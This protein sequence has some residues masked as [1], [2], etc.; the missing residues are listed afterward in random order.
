MSFQASGQKLNIVINFHK[1]DQSSAR[2]LLELLV[3][4]DEGIE[5][6]YYL[7]YGDETATIR[8]EETLL[9]FIETKNA[10]FSNKFPDIV[11]PDE[12]IKNDVNQ[13]R[14]NGNHTFKS[15]VQ[16]ARILCWNLAVYKY[17]NKLDHFLIIE[18]DCVIMRED[19]AKPIFE[20]WSN[21][22]NPIVGH[23]KRGK[24]SGQLIPTHWAGCSVY[25]GLALRQLP[26]EKYFYE[27]YENPWWPLRSE[28]GTTT[29]NNAF[30]GPAI[31]GYDIS[32]DYFLFALYFRELT[33]SN[34]PLEWPLNDLSSIDDIIL[35]DFKSKLRVEEIFEQ[36]YGRL[37]VL[38]GIK[39]DLVHHAVLRT[40][41]SHNTRE[42]LTFPIGGGF[43]FADQ[44]DTTTRVDSNLKAPM[45]VPAGEVFAV[46]QKK[47][48]VL[49]RS[50]SRLVSIKDLRSRFSG[51]RCFIIGNGPSL[52]NTDLT[53][54][55][56][57]FTIGLNRIYLNYPAMGFQPTFYCSVNPSV[58]EQFS[59]EIDS[60]NS[61]KFLR[62]DSAKHLANQWNTFFMKSIRGIGFNENLENQ[63]WFE[64]WT[65]TFCAMQVAYHLGFNDVVL[66]GVD[67][68]FE[69]S[70]KPN[71]TVR[72]TADD[73]NHFDPTYFG[74][75]VVW[76]YPDLE[77]SEQSYKIAKEIF[78]SDGRR[79]L[80]AT[81]GGH[82]KIFEKAD[83]D[84]L[85]AFAA[86]LHAPDVTSPGAGEPRPLVSVIM[87]AQDAADTIAESIRSVQAQDY[88][89]WELLIIN[90]LSQ[91]S[92][93]EIVARFQEKDSRIRIL[94]SAGIGTSA[95]RNTGLR[96]AA[97]AFIT[98]LDSDDIY[99]PGSIRKRV[100]ALQK[101]PTWPIVSCDAHLIDDGFRKLGIRVRQNKSKFTFADS[102]RNL[103][104]NSLMGRAAVLRRFSFDSEHDGVED[105]VYLSR[106]LRAG[107]SVFEV[108][109][110]AVAYRI[111]ANSV[112]TADFRAHEE[113]CRRVINLVYGFDSKCPN[114]VPEYVNGLTSPDK[115][116][117]VAKRQIGLLT[118][119]ILGRKL[120]D[121]ARLIGEIDA[122][123]VHKMG[124][125]DIISAMQMATIRFFSCKSDKWKDRL[126]EESDR[127]LYICEKGDVTRVLPRYVTILFKC[128]QVSEKQ[129]TTLRARVKAANCEQTYA[130]ID[131]ATLAG[132]YDRE[133][134]AHFDE[135]RLAYEL[136]S[137]RPAKSVMIDV[138]AHH[139]SAL[140]PFADRGW[141]VY[142]FEPDSANREKLLKRVK[143]NSLVS[144]D[145]RAVCD[146]I[147]ESVPLY[148]SKE[149]TGISTLAP[150][151]DSHKKSSRVGTTTLAAVSEEHGLTDVDFLKIDTEGYDLMVL[152]GLP[153]ECWR[154]TVIVC[155]FEDRKTVPLGYDYHQ[156]AGFLVDKGYAVLVS[157][158][159]PVIR[160]GI[161]HDW[162]RLIPYPCRL[163]D[164][165]SWGNLIAFP[166]PP[167]LD[168]VA[169][170]AQRIVTSEAGKAP[171]T[172]RSTAER[173]TSPE[174]SEPVRDK[175]GAL[176]LTDRGAKTGEAARMREPQETL[177]QRFASYLILHHP[178]LARIARF[179]LWSLRK[180]KERM[181]GLGGVALLSIGGLFAGA[182][183]S[184][185]YR[186]L[187][188]GAGVGLLLVL[189]GGLAL[190]Y[191][192]FLF[193]RFAESQR[194]EM[195][196]TS[197]RVSRQL[198]QETAELRGSLAAL[199]AGVGGRIGEVVDAAAAR[200]EEKLAEVRHLAQKA[201]SAH[202]IVTAGLRQPTATGDEE[203]Q[204]E[205]GVYDQFIRKAN[206][207]NS[208]LFQHFSRQLRSKDLDRLLTFWVPAL[209]LE[210]D[211]QA[212][213]YLAHRICLAEDTCS[214]RLA[215]SV[216]N[217]LLRVLV[218]RS[219][220][221]DSLE[222]LEIGTLFGVNLV[223]LYETS[224]GCFT[225]LHLTAI[226]PLEGYYD[227]G[228]VDIVTNIPVTSSL[229]EHNMRRMDVPQDDVTLIQAVSTDQKARRQAAKRRYNLLIIDGDHSYQGVKHDFERYRKMLQP[230][231]Y[232][233][234]DDFDTPEWPEVKAFVDEEVRPRSDLELVGAEWRTI[235]F[236]AKGKPE[237]SSD[238]PSS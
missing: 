153:W 161:R 31:S 141:R 179:G 1:N 91:D 73:V 6:A 148:T 16:K 222:V 156:L 201:A 125:A 68:F 30:L 206:Y 197:E 94:E 100:S 11:I 122:R 187:F 200:S 35:C 77:R 149:S 151:R 29:A 165:N 181:F 88:E 159:H 41:R 214:G 223:I 238:S 92:T 182:V 191:A 170:I 59:E 2:M 169:A 20:A 213:G 215:T 227:S 106:I 232:I 229:F 108:K 34:N 234:F 211:R 26:L 76:Q 82:L 225:D 24:I 81:I 196:A 71:K 87:A 150:F 80:D 63:E 23:L 226:D 42:N 218:A 49:T 129:I 143:E 53:R 83:Y 107:F 61:V 136:L 18:P 104:P 12:M 66:V 118:C 21:R 95:A 167:D 103:H 56:D 138:G 144:V 124:K 17:I 128:C 146:E 134:H 10:S 86:G 145:G 74:K 75:G 78:E 162:R 36:F 176:A 212:L 131:S 70:G 228:K 233:I 174:P 140:G 5:T 210:L 116:L 115:G 46:S 39:D 40:V 158:W 51:E 235:V 99:Y 79:I 177:Y 96:S 217:A 112:I 147:R 4:L 164:P 130:G 105:W 194:R 190:G 175:V 37:S 117:V 123:F 204:Q 220:Q 219:I 171:A 160:Y 183:I 155:E 64:G 84:E 163:A 119:L 172:P 32:Y 50:N 189:A 25:D 137:D 168:A 121:I 188:A 127:I 111:R 3:S 126:T 216:Q 203:I 110:C 157:E 102:Y 57:E 139:G 132:P 237:V 93:A 230:G 173:A 205:L 236:R 28:P 152:K 33:G 224:R 48:N 133:D 8:I 180:L 185:P 58:I 101:N 120:R 142:A 207:L 27:R 19:C 85:T 154:P 98:F 113:R 15:R 202:E 13:Q 199:E 9:K 65:V 38:H 135:S 109:D 60:L 90:D 14:F 89:S 7:Q 22:S 178:T 195:Q 43:D 62:A 54:L 52:R 208:A 47:L 193:Y 192:Q 184:E 44:G 45:R 186:W 69:R 231:G 198:K 72:S 209:G 166:K 221:S 67:H 97:G 114:A 55:R